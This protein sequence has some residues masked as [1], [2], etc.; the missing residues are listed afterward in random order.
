MLGQI[1]QDLCPGERLERAQVVDVLVHAE[2][3]KVVLER[4]HS[5]DQERDLLGLRVALHP[6]NGEVVGPGLGCSLER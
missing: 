3:L 1:L 2:A 4:L 6:A 5:V